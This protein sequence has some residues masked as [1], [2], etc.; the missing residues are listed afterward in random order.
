MVDTI[1]CQSELDLTDAFL[2]KLLLGAIDKGLDHKRMDRHTPIRK[3]QNSLP[4]L[5]HRFKATGKGKEREGSDDE[6]LVGSFSRGAAVV[7][8]SQSEEECLSSL[9][10]LHMHDREKEIA[11]AADDTC[12]WLPK[13]PNYL[14]WFNRKS[15]MLWITGNPGVGKSTIMKYV[16]EAAMRSTNFVSVSFFCHGRGQLLQRSAT[17][18]LRSILYQLASKIPQLR[19]R[20]SLGFKDRCKIDGPIGTNWEWQESDLW[21]LFRSLVKE[22]AKSYT[23]RLYIDALDECGEHSALE[24]VQHFRHVVDDVS[25][26]FS[27]RHYPFIMPEKETQI[28]LERENWQD[29]RTYVDQ[30]ITTSSFRDAEKLRTEIQQKSSGNF[31]WVCLVVREAKESAK[32]GISYQTQLQG[33]PEQLENLYENLLSSLEI[34]GRVRCLKLM[35]WTCFAFRPL[36]LPELRH[37]MAVDADTLHTSVRDLE[38]TEFYVESDD[39]MEKQ[40]RHLSGGLVEVVQHGTAKV[41]QFIHQSVGEFLLKRGLRQIGLEPSEGSLIGASNFRL[42]RS[43]LRYLLL[44]EVQARKKPSGTSLE[45]RL[46]FLRYATIHWTRHAEDAEKWGISQIDL[47]T[48]IQLSSSFMQSWIDAYKDF[49]NSINVCPPLGTT[50]LHIVSRHNLHSTLQTALDQSHEADPRD[51]QGRTPLSWAALKGHGAVVDFLADQD[52]VDINSKDKSSR[53]PLLLAA[54]EG[55][56]AVVALLIRRP[57][58][59]VDMADDCDQ[60]PL[61]WAARR[62]HLKIVNLLVQQAGAAADK[63]DRWSRTP[64]SWA[65]QKGHEVVVKYLLDLPTVNANSEDRDGRTPLFWAA[66]YGHE[67]IVNL[68]IDQDRDDLGSMDRLDLTPLS[69][70]VQGRHKEISEM[71]LD[72]FRSRRDSDCHQLLLFGAKKGLMLLVEFIAQR[73]TNDIDRKDATGMTPLA[74][75]AMNGHE[76]VVKY[77]ADRA[78]VYTDSQDQSGLTPL[79]HAAMN[80]HE[81]VVKFLADRADVY[82]DSQDQSGLT[83][84]AGAAR[85]G[86]YT[87]VAL[88]LAMDSIDLNH[89]DAD[90]RTPLSW[91]AA[92]GHE[93]IIRLLLTTEGVNPNSRDHYGQTPLFL[94]AGNGHNIAVEILLAKVTVDLES[95]DYFNRT[96]LSWAAQKGHFS[97]VRLL[98]EKCKERGISEGLEVVTSLTSNEEGRIRCNICLSCIP[99]IMAHYHCRICTQGN[100][101]LCQDCLAYGAFCFHQ[102]HVLTKRIPKGN[103]FV[104][105][106][107]ITA[108]SSSTSRLSNH[109][110]ATVQAHTSATKGVYQIRCKASWQ[111]LK[112]CKEQ[113]DGSYNLHQVVTIT[114]TPTRAQAALCKDFVEEIWGAQGLALLDGLVRFLSDESCSGSVICAQSMDIKPLK[115]MNRSS[116]SVCISIPTTPGVAEIAEISISGTLDDVVSTVEQLAWFAAVFRPPNSNHLAASSVI[117]SRLKPTGLAASSFG[118]QLDMLNSDMFKSHPQAEN[119]PSCWQHLFQGGVLAF[120]FPIAQRDEGSGLEIPFELMTFFAQV[121]VSM[122]HDAG[123]ILLGD[124]SCLFPAKRLQTGVQWHFVKSSDSDMIGNV[125]RSCSERIC[126]ENL[127]ALTSRRTFLGVYT[128]AR[129]LLGTEELVQNNKIIDSDLDDSTSKIELAREGTTTAGLSIKGFV[130]GTIGGRWTVPRGL[131]VNMIENREYPDRLEKAEKRPILVYDCRIKSAWLVSELSLVLHLVLTY[132]RRPRVQQ[133]R[134]N[135]KGRQPEDWPQLPFADARSDGGAA[136]HSVICSNHDLYLYTNEQGEEKLFW[137]VVDD[138]LKDLRSLRLAVNLKKAASGWP[139]FSSRLQG[140]DFTDLATKEETIH[141]RELPTDSRKVSWWKL[142]D[143]KDMLV[144]FGRDFGQLITPDLNKTKV[145]RGWECL[146][147]QAELL[148]ASMPCVEQLMEQSKPRKEQGH[149]YLMPELAWH[150]PTEKHSS[151]SDHCNSSCLCIHELRQIHSLRI[152]SGGSEINPPKHLSSSGAA[153]F[154]DPKYYHH[155]LLL[156]NS[157]CQ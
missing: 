33:V 106:E 44:D 127:S 19:Q 100:F 153:I 35:Q 76:K 34:E 123:T 107:Q 132:I 74:H 46:P 18:L 80:G 48:H 105:E 67:S 126:E 21:T 38:K 95:R 90:G 37:C 63:G 78:D 140:W 113:L 40:A 12:V 149:Y 141:Q 104:D 6:T 84:L 65:A 5:S 144:V 11:N 138:F 39:D 16:S 2:E 43:C 45:E 111:I 137:N 68:L 93:A 136:A 89:K 72:Q 125:L 114:G 17:G 121:R 20:L 81:K 85:K 108:T 115:D 99:N 55:H 124:T 112:F 49:D 129:V 51:E 1:Q 156:R 151:C 52:D 120:G 64:L 128:S 82:A 146:P 70:A 130:N 14:K 32:D 97:V 147:P 157:L 50:M 109:I 116:L 77:L 15:G 71:L 122:T 8:D 66:F 30:E 119:I 152:L 148:V 134:R 117:F 91:A 143:S 133:R 98:R 58:I 59:K 60:T 101:D 88:L 47:L 41:A 142:S 145:Y 155:S 83:P 103:Y 42:S 31:L 131:R 3:G 36:S 54:R 94:A 86:C 118:L 92:R 29:I 4:P 26:C 25:I 110:R 139:I 28:F 75:A 87:S 7:P 53:T 62:G 61:L 13:D 23:I 10:F 56:E 135:Q 57:D 96:P 22:F 9:S 27:C 69:A 150:K 79:A 73:S 154:G 102:S 24:V